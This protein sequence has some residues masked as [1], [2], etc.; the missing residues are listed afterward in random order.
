MTT[1]EPAANPEL[2][3]EFDRS[4]LLV[5]DMQD[6]FAEGG[7][8]PVPGTRAVAP[9]VA[10][11][12][13]AYRQAARPVVHAIRLY[14][15]DDVDRVRRPAIAGG[16]RIV[17]PGTQGSQVI[18]GLLPEGAPA[19]DPKLLLAGDPQLV[20]P[21]ECVLWKPRW[22]AFYR[23]DLHARL[24]TAQV[25]TLVV[26]GCNFPNCPRASLFDASER[27]YRVVLVT[28]A[29][30]G[31]TEGHIEESARIGVVPLATAAV[32]AALAAPAR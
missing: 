32:L 26:V 27:D 5:I 7:G 15:G 3:P 2:T 13:A 28:D 23:T 16:A 12:A 18:A 10:R 11:L 21:A 29:V 9:A 17:R 4:A 31:V 22:S 24:I 8:S 20:G 14:D 6:D 1:A 30:S 19:L 25:S